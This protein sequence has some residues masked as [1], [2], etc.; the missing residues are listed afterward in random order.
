MRFEHRVAIVTGS[1]GGIGRATALLLARE[2]AHVVVADLD[3]TAADNVV[4]EIGRLGPAA[5]AVKTDVAIVE[6]VKAL[7][8][9]IVSRFGRI[10]VLVNNAANLALAAADMDVVNAD[11]DLWDQ[12]YRINL[13]GAVATCKFAIP[14]MLERGGGTIVN[15]SSV[16]SMSGDMRRLA[17][18]SSKAG[19]NLLTQ[20]IATSYGKRGIRCNGVSPGIAMQKTMQPRLPPDYL[21]VLLGNVLTPDLGTPEQIAEVI[22][23]LASDEAGFV[24]GQILA[25]DGGMMAHM[26]WHAGM[27]LLADQSMR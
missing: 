8:D 6:D 12:T 25:A 10:D 24:T 17:Y 16:A 7:I 15:V 2:G 27:E 18:G 22:V 3:E 23:F 1:G 11:F 13:R 14:H 21:A 5:L 26:P 9:K 4:A 19:L 20:S